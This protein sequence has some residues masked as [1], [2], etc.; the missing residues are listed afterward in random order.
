MA[1]A[2]PATFPALS[3]MGSVRLPPLV[4]PQTLQAAASHCAE[5]GGNRDALNAAALAGALIQAHMLNA[6][7]AAGGVAQPAMSSTASP[8]GAMPMGGAV[9]PVT[10]ISPAPPHTL[11]AV[12]PAMPQAALFLPQPVGAASTHAAEAATAVLNEQAKLAMT[13]AQATNWAERP[14]DGGGGPPR[15]SMGA[16]EPFRGAKDPL[17]PGDL[18]TPPAGV[19]SM[20]GMAHP[21]PAFGG[22]PTGML[23]HTMNPMLF[24]PQMPPSLQPPAQQAPPL[25]APPAQ[26][27]PP[28]LAMLAAQPPT[29]RPAREL[30]K[31]EPPK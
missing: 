4:H 21:M 5:F 31:R 16:P 3:A 13:A 10:H 6:Q 1:M 28:Q 8:M 22:L 2:A 9:L 18:L 7:K 17:M 25:Q 23:Q 19:L 27:P 14:R 24:V 11:S 30:P 12:P 15:P 20:A 26:Q 29:V